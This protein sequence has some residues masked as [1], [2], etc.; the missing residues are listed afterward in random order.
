MAKK[1]KKVAGEYD[2]TATS[3]RIYYPHY[4]IGHGDDEIR[5]EIEDRPYEEPP[6]IEHGSNRARERRTGKKF[7]VK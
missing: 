7:F 4:G 1:K 6:G 5:K 2:L 3:S